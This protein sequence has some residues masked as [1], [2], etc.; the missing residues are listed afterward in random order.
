MNTTVL[1]KFTD[2]E[3]NWSYLIMYKLTNRELFKV[4]NELLNLLS[5]RD[6]L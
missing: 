5:E 1:H 3:N 2:I 4:L 6:E